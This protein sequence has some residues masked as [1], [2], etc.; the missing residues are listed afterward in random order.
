M[1]HKEGRGGSASY[2][3]VLGNLELAMI[4]VLAVPDCPT[5]AATVANLRQ[6]LDELGRSPDEMTVRVIVD[7]RAAIEAGMRGS[8]TV[9]IDGTDPFSDIGAPVSV[10]CRLYAGAGRS[11]APSVDLLRQALEAHGAAS[12]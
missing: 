3:R 5:V 1:S 10:S 6:A 2:W 4:E 8:P 9:L 12:R 11:P 7:E